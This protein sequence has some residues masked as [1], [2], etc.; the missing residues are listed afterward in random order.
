MVGSGPDC[1]SGAYNCGGGLGWGQHDVPVAVI[2]ALRV[3]SPSPEVAAI[4]GS[5]AAQ[6][7]R[8]VNICMGVLLRPAAT[9]CLIA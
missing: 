3:V 2:P 8:M 1:A 5:I 7:R 6:F 4:A 9:W